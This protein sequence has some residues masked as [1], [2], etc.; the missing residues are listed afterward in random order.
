MKRTTRR[1]F[2]KTTTVAGLGYCVAGGVTLARSRSANQKLNVACIGVGGRGHANLH[3]VNSENVVALC[4][5]DSKMAERAFGE[6]PDARR[7]ICLLYTSPSPRDRTR[8]RM[9][10]SA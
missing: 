9:P 10:S 6:F 4:D 7:Y 3:G 5:V 1:N 8:S 2:I